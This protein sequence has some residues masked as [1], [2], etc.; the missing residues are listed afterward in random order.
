MKFNTRI[1]VGM[2]VLLSIVLL[3][4]S[5]LA[6]E[7]AHIATTELPGGLTVLTDDAGRTLYASTADVD[8]VSNCTAECAE[9]WQPLLTSGRAIVGPGLIPGFVGSVEREEGTQVTF[10]R[11]PL[12]YY[13]GDSEPGDVLG[14]GID[15]SW[16]VVTHMGALHTEELPVA[17]DVVA[18]DVS[19][20]VDEEVMEIGQ[21]IYSMY[22]AAC[23]GNNGSGGGGGPAVA[24]GTNIGN[25]NYVLGQIVHG[26]AEMPTFGAILDDEQVAA[27]S[28]YV[29][30]SFGNSYAPISPAEV[31]AIR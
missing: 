29:R 16:F 23:H 8:G 7:P 26:G 12:Y 2:G 20:E 6:A 9:T 11:Q 28:T 30:N 14:H 18:E 5:V 10:L 1:Q 13:S 27:V 3:S 31:E 21:E 25:T 22:C 19:F 15:D 24:S 17:D 4:G